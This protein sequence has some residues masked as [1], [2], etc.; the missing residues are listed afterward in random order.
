MN[1]QNK[2]GPP[3]QSNFWIP[4][5]FV[6]VVMESLLVSNSV[7]GIW[8]DKK[9]VHSTLDLLWPETGAALGGAAVCALSYWTN[10]RE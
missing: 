9:L 7:F 5:L 3:A 8:S 10:H 2:P 1:K 4:F 6:F